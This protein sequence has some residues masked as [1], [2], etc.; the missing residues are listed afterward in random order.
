MIRPQPPSVAAM[1]AAA[2]RHQGTAGS[3]ES[4]PPN[5][6]CL[7]NAAKRPRATKLGAGQRPLGQRVTSM[8]QKTSAPSAAGAGEGQDQAVAVD[9]EV[10]WRYCWMWVVRRPARPWRSIEYCQARNSSTVSV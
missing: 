1:A 9:G 8:M 5:G 7:V 2:R 4:C 6:Y 3:A 10:Y